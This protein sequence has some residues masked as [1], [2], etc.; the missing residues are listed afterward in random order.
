MW[1]EQSR[2]VSSS[3]HKQPGARGE[4]P[5]AADAK[6]LP[7]QECA[8]M[9]GLHGNQNNTKGKNFILFTIC[10]WRNGAEEQTPFP[11]CHSTVAPIITQHPPKL[12]FRL[13]TG[14][15]PSADSFPPHTSIMAAT[16]QHWHKEATG[17]T[18]VHSHSTHIPAGRECPCPSRSAVSASKQRVE[19]R[20]FYPERKKEKEV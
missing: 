12:Y 17:V 13:R 8:S 20:E 2:P 7:P 19:E 10:V 14:G 16:S 4:V 5:A 15:S 1:E 11:S 6:Q 9:L 3:K 18:G